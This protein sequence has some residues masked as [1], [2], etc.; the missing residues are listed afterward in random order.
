MIVIAEDVDP[1]RRDKLLE[2]AGKCPVHRTLMRGFEI[3]SSVA[4]REAPLGGEPASQHMQDM[5][6]ACED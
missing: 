3:S 2:I 4:S 6:A 5:S 1:E